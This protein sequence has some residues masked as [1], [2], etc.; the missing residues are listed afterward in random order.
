MTM[1]GSIKGIDQLSITVM[2]EGTEV[3]MEYRFE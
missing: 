2:R 3:E 1:F